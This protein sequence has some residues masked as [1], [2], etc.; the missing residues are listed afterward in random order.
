M[1]NNEIAI[2]LGIGVITILIIV[3]ILLLLSIRK[4]KKVIPINQE[5]FGS[6]FIRSLVMLFP[7]MIITS[8]DIYEF[9]VIMV[10]LIFASILNTQYFLK[11]NELKRED[12]K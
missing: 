3:S 4:S 7:A 1:D 6:V 12:K 10:C 2:K 8:K 11:R 5:I 9:F